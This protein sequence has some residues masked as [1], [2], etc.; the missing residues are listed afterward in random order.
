MGM[1]SLVVSTILLGTATYRSYKD[2]TS[3][4]G[5]VRR[6]FELMRRGDSSGRRKETAERGE[7]EVNTGL[8]AI[9]GA[10]RSWLLE[11]CWPRKEAA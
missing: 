4:P 9:A 7:A 8:E 3:A 5:R 11:P 1:I 2:E 10:Q 6:E